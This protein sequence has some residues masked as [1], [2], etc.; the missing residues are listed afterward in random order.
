MKIRNWSLLGRLSLLTGLL[1]GVAVFPAAAEDR[2]EDRSGKLE[3]TWTEVVTVRD[4]G[5]GAAL[6]S[7]T[8]I[9]TFNS[10][11]TMTDTTAGASLSMR[12]PGHGKWEKT[13]KGTYDV[14][15]LALLFNPA[16]DWIGTQK[17]SIVAVVT[18]DDNTFTTTSEFFDTGGTKV[19]VAACA[20]AVGHRL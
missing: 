17:L 2:S 20:T 5:S 12:S 16:G 6:F 8:G 18:G 7:F 3:G 19:G 1:L 15:V 10:G 11:G 9:T 14:T 4:C 13:G